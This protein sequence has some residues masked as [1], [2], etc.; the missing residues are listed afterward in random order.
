M[1]KP[2]SFAESL[3]AWGS[4]A[5]AVAAEF[6]EVPALRERGKALAALVG[7][8]R[9]VQAESAIHEASLRAANREKV[10]LYREGR[11][12]RNE[13]ALQLRVVLGLESEHLS[14]FGVP[15]QRQGI[16]RPR[17]N[18]AAGKGE[19]PAAD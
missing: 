10:V 6:G 4:M 19:P 11:K 16:R 2:K 18:K 17:R 1:A 15:P 14:A 3:V 7:R 12:L 13:I 8:G 9:E 5:S